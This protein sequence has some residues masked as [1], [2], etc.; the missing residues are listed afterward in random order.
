MATRKQ[1]RSDVYPL[2]IAP[3]E[4]RLWEAAAAQEEQTLAEFLRT[5][6]SAAARVRLTAPTEAPAS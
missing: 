3:A 2:R 1:T 4:R 5:S 6:A